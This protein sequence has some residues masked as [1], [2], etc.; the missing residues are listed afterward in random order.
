MNLMS[1]KSKPKPVGMKKKS[2]LAT[3]NLL[4]IL[5]IVI[6]ASAIFVLQPKLM[7]AK[8]ITETIAIAKMDMES[9]HVITEKDIAFE[10]RG[11]YGFKNYVT[12]K[13]DLIGRQVAINISDGDIITKN[14]IGE[15]NLTKIQSIMNEGKGLTTISVKTNAA[16]LAS[17][18]VPGDEVR[19]YSILT[20][21]YNNIYIVQDP[22]LNNVEVFGVENSEAKDINRKSD[23]AQDTS[24]SE[25][26]VSTITLITTPEQEQVLLRAEYDGNLHVVLAGRGK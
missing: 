22:I 16:G 15:E 19:C 1:K 3:R 4:G 26:V 6:A 14:K 11:T 13:N 8:Q 21:E 25:M 12:D 17:H 10:E 2:G 24:G 5:L 20:D 23:T 18:L 9:G 7:E